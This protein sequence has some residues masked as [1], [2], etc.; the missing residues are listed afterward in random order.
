MSLIGK[1][2]NQSYSGI[3]QL[4]HCWSQYEPVHDKTNKMT[5]A[6]S[7]GS[8]RA[9]AT[10]SDQSLRCPHEETLD[11]KLP[12]EHTVKTQIR[13]GRCPGWAESSL[14]AH[15]I[16]LVFVMQRLTYYTTERSARRQEQCSVNHYCSIKLSHGWFPCFQRISFSE[17]IH[18]MESRSYC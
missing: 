10:Q 2:D 17:L 15:V 13:L 6:P 9:F 3:K 7:K 12:I 16:L 11:L 8:I 1:M 14:G 4:I 18:K 5:C